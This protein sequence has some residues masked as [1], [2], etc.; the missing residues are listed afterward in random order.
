M[1]I[2]HVLATKPDV[3]RRL[4]LEVLGFCADKPRDRCPTYEELEHLVYINNFLKE[5]LRFYSP[6]KHLLYSPRNYR[7]SQLTRIF[8]PRE[9]AEDVTVCGVFI[10]K[11]TQVTLCPAVAHFNPSVWGDT[12]EVFDPDRWDDG[13]ASKDSYAMEAFLQ[14]PA[15]CIAKNMALLNIKSVIFALVRNFTFSSR[16]GWDGV[17]ELANPNFTLRPKESLRVTVERELR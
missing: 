10:P 1:W 5:I 13:R 9:A 14:G 16:P 6:G 11:G 3:Q 12:A 17:L 7:A 4:K 2:A 8:L 15:G